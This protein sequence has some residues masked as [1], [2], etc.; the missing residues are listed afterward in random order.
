MTK[1]SGYSTQCTNYRLLVPEPWSLALRAAAQ[2]LQPVALHLKGRAPL[3]LAHQRVK[4]AVFGE[5]EHLTAA[6]AD[7][8]VMV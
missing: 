3:D 4:L 5:V 8:V 7:Q 6:V 1:E 2:Q